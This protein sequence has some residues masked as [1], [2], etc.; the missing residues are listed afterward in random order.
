[1]SPPETMPFLLPACRCVTC[2]HWLYWPPAHILSCTVPQ[3]CLKQLAE[4]QTY[5]CPLCSKTYV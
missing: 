2:A 1:M 5:V 4:H 3:A